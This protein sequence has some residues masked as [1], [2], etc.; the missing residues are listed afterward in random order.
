MLTD[1][2][3]ADAA[4]AAA[5][6][7]CAGLLIAAGLPGRLATAQGSCC[8]RHTFGTAPQRRTPVC[9]RPHVYSSGQVCIFCTVLS[10]NATS[11][12]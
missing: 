4:A 11:T 2:G 9:T 5:Q 8:R 1:A 10:F 6:V 7:G 12:G 3:S